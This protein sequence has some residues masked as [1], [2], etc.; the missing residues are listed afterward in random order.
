MQIEREVKMSISQNTDSIDITQISLSEYLTSRYP[1][2]RVDDFP[3]FLID[4][5]GELLGGGFNTI[6]EVAK[7]LERTKKAAECFE[8]QNPRS[9]L[10]DSQ[11][12][13]IGIVIISIALLRGADF[14]TF[15]TVLDNCLPEKLEEYRKLILP[16]TD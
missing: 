11:Y 2:R 13:A 4:L 5:V 6:D 7:T 8:I 14:F 9:Q 1:N 3:Y 15:R 16:E 10:V 12:S